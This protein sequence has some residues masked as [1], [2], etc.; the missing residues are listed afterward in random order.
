MATARHTEALTVPKANPPAVSG[1]VSQS[2]SVAPSGQ[3][4]TKAAQNSST[5]LIRVPT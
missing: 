4:S 2:P 3:V 1:L 5:R